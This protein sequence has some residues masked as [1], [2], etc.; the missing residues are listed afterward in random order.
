MRGVAFGQRQRLLS[1]SLVI[2]HEHTRCAIGQQPALRALVDGTQLRRIVG[3]TILRCKSGL[4]YGW[5]EAVR[6]DIGGVGVILAACWRTVG[7]P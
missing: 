5:P 7:A 4:E 6:N 3:Q 1:I 2:Q